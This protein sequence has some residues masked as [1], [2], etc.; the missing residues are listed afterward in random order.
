ML[1]TLAQIQT[2]SELVYS[3]IPPSPQYCWPLLCDELGAEVWMKHENH[4]PIGAFKVRGGLIY[5]SSL[6]KSIK[7]VVTAT[8]GNHGQ[9][10]ALAAK[11]YDL[12][13][14]VVVPFGNSAEKNAA[15]R[16]LGA[17]LI[18]HGDDFQDAREHAARVAEMSGAHMVPSFH[19][20]LVQGVATYAL[21][22]FRAVSG[23]GSIYV[24]IGLGSGICG[25]VAARNALCPQTK[26][27]GVVSSHARAY[28]LSF[29]AKQPVESE[30]TT[31]LADGMACRMPQPEA[32]DI[33]WRYVDRIVE[34]S[35]SEI[36]EAMRVI[37]RCTHN[38]AEGA[39]AAPVAA[40][41]KERSR[42]HGQKVALVLSGGNVDMQTFASVLAGQWSAS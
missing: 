19:P 5:F 20:L 12:A 29:A 35:D 14:T 21:E 1:P 30:V 2:A 36:A 16:S 17:T 39:G 9:S 42:L 23:I 25:V 27:I 41:L 28:A 10:V 26:V 33:I 11:R 38:C 40:A 22:L 34:V 24:P 31:K 8:R 6:A 3:V 15:M 32:L 37:Y 4:T 18:E 7:A 13:A